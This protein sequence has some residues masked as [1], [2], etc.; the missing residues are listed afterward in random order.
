MFQK[1]I[2]QKTPQ[3]PQ[4]VIDLKLLETHL[5][6]IKVRLLEIRVFRKKK[7]VRSPAYHFMQNI[8]IEEAWPSCC[9]ILYQAYDLLCRA[10]QNLQVEYQAMSPAAPFGMAI[11]QF[12]N[13]IDR[14]TILLETTENAAFSEMDL[15]SIN[16]AILRI[17][18][19]INLLQKHVMEDFV[20]TRDSTN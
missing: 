13:L 19:S 7:I 5:D 3:K 17:Q 4:S 12:V 1:F 14:V 10:A 6:S 16:T 8:D 18:K 20:F 11:D 15:Q 2:T 9:D